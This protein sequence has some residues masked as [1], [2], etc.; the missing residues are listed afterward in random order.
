[1]KKKVNN[2]ISR[3]RQRHE[4]KRASYSLASNTIVLHQRFLVGITKLWLEVLGYSRSSSGREWSAETRRSTWEASGAGPPRTRTC[5]PNRGSRPVKQS[6][7]CGEELDWTLLCPKT[8]SK[9]HSKLKRP[10]FV[11]ISLS[12][13]IIFLPVPTSRYLRFIISCIRS[14]IEDCFQS[15]SSTCLNQTPQTPPWRWGSIETSWF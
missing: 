1:M 7:G 13:D 10:Q 14:F 6:N 5:F 15:R 8:R 9:L 4:S 2:L 12:W 3:L 11:S